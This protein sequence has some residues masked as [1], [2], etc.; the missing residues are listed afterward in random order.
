[1][2]YCDIKHDD[3]L[4]G[5]GIRVTL[6]VSG[7]N[8]YCKNCQNPQTWNPH[9]GLPFKMEDYIEIYNELQKDYVSGITLTGGDPLLPDN[10]EAIKLLINNLKI[11]FPE[12]TIW[13]YT[14]YTYNE[15]INDAVL[16]EILNYVDVLCD[17][18][19]IKELKDS[20]LHWVGSSNQNVI[21]IPKRI[22][23]V[24]KIIR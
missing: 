1:M 5:D 6:F 11:A 19:F 18:P 20:D 12:K 22:S 23:Q 24:H 13:L 10:R 2:N 3:M 8:H 17:G 7:C 9:Y 21:D 14:G 4:N 16:L 15:I